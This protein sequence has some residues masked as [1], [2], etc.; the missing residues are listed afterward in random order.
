MGSSKGHWSQTV[1][2][3]ELER[4]VRAVLRD[5]QVLEE[6]EHMQE[7]RRWVRQI[8]RILKRADRQT[9]TLDSEVGHYNHLP[10]RLERPLTESVRGV[11]TF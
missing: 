1:D 10:Y 5:K 3:E 7:A 4:L 6:A 9:S 11:A 2:H 8:P